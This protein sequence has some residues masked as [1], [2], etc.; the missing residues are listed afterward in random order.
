MSGSRMRETGL[1]KQYEFNIQT[2]KLLPKN[3]PAIK[4]KG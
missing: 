1:G 3:K 4:N 2:N